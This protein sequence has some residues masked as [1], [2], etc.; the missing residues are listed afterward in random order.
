MTLKIGNLRPSVCIDAVYEGMPEAEAIRRIDAIGYDV[1]E[2]W[3]WWE[4]DLDEI[5][6]LCD[7]L[8]LQVASCCT[9]FISLTNESCREEYLRGLKESV[10]AAQ[11]L[12]CPTLISQVG[13]FLP[14]ISREQQHQSIV[15]GLRAAADILRDSGVTLV[16]EP[17][18][19]K[20]DHPGYYLVRSPEAFEIVQEVDSPDIKVVFDIYHQQISEGDLLRKI[21]PNLERIGHFH[22]AGNPGRNELNRGEIN[23]PDIFEQIAA[24]GFDGFVG[25]EYWPKGDPDEGLAEVAQW[26]GKRPSSQRN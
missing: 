25:L 24:A 23:Y 21:L 1:F 26:F 12:K 14:E 7:E 8:G 11:R 5:S 19:D 16:I 10:R 3:C 20:V 9:R 18:N 6:G 15:Q 17:L 4:K 13:D 2:F 22:A